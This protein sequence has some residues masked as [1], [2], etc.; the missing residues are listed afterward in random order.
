MNAFIFDFDGVIVDSE[1]HWRALGDGE[2][3]PALIPGWTHADGARM[4]GKSIQ[5]GYDL[6][7]Q[8]YGLQMPFEEYANRVHQL[9]NSIYY[10]SKLQLLPGLIDL[11]HRIE[12]LE[13]HIGIASSGSRAWITTILEK[14]QLTKHFPVIVDS[15]DVHGHA[16]PLPDIYVLAAEKLHVDPTACIAL[17]DSRN[18]VISAKAAGMYTIGVRTDMSVEQDLSQADRIVRHYDELTT[19]V[20]K[21]IEKS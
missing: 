9:T 15:A 3:Y 11:I 6:L 1:R 14:F 20:L 4:M 13:W 12:Q 21:K 2:L 17:E 5:A 8:E 10:Q 19:E 18:G 7:V 16:K